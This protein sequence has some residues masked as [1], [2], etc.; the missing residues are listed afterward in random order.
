VLVLVIGIG[1][2][3]ARKYIFPSKDGFEE[4]KIEKLETVSDYR[5][6]LA[7]LERKIGFDTFANASLEQGQSAQFTGGEAVK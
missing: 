1:F 2:F 6:L 3:M 4:A 7:N 5:V